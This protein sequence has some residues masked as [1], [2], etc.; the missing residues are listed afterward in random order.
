MMMH[1]CNIHVVCRVI[2]LGWWWTTTHQT[3]SLL[4]HQEWLACKTQCHWQRLVISV[5]IFT[6]WRINV[7]TAV[8]L[9]IWLISSSRQIK[10]ATLLI[11]GLCLIRYLILSKLYFFYIQFLFNNLLRFYLVSSIK[12]KLLRMPLLQYSFILK[13]VLWWSMRFFFK[14]KSLSNTLHEKGQFF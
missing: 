6:S 7:V 10:R 1:G 13:F 8:L 14:K 11:Q 5:K 4:S 3:M 12:R 2:L 9:N